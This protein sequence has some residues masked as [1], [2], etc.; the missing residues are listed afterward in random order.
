MRRLERER[1]MGIISEMNVEYKLDY[2][3][4]YVVL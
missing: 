3:K 2:I 1:V 4:K